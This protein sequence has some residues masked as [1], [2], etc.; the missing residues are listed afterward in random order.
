[1]NSIPV[2]KENKPGIV[3]KI[4]VWLL[5]PLA[6]FSAAYNILSGNV[7]RPAAFYLVIGGFLLFTIG[8]LSVIV[9]KKRVSFGTKLMSQNMANLYRV[10]Y[11]LMFVG[12]IFTFVP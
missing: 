11:W 5:I 1:M 4:L 7:L 12:I 9:Q 2:M 3:S 8:K 6:G 10:G